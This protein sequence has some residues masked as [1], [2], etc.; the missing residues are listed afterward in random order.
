M[1]DTTVIAPQT[2]QEAEELVKNFYQPHSASKTSQV[3]KTLQGIQRS[4]DGW[5]FANYLLQSTD[6]NCNFFG[7]LTFQVKLNNDTD[8]LS[9]QE[10]EELLSVLLGWL[11]RAVD[12]GD[13]R[14]VVKKLCS[15]LVTYF[16]RPISVW[17]NPLRHTICSLSQG[18][19]VQQDTLDQYGPTEELLNNLS[20][21][22]RLACLWVDT[23]LVDE[24]KKVKEDAST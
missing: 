16:L 20:G 11:L 18:H 14:V 6:S 2:A 17:K 23:D 3:E 12:R 15:A 1:T 19:V 5:N 7:A 22:Q 13:S 8:Q 21:A 9:E 4:A 24:T 10:S